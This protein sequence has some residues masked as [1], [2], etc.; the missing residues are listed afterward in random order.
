LKPK[1]EKSQDLLLLQHEG[2]NP[3]SGAYTNAIY[4][5]RRANGRFTVWV[6]AWN[7]EGAAEDCWQ[8]DLASAA[9]FVSAC[10]TCLEFVEFGEADVVDVIRGGFEGLRKLD[11]SFAES[12]RACLLE[13]FS[14]DCAVEPAPPEPPEIRS[15][16]VTVTRLSNEEARQKYGSSMI[17]ITDSGQQPPEDRRGPAED[18][19][20]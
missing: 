4:A 18:A 20:R 2:Q 14:E 12:L 1:S 17:F 13:Q 16:R 15:G 7:S 19:G 10:Q 3:F 11:A 6:K 9:E 5:R 8:K